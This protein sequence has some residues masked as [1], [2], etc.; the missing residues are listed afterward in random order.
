MYDRVIQYLNIGHSH[1]LCIL[2]MSLYSTECLGYS[3]YGCYDVNHILVTSQLTPGFFS[4]TAYIKI[5]MPN[6]HVCVQKLS[7][8]CPTCGYW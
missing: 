1:I 7:S 3:C 6:V 4:N 5:Q 8:L 2:L